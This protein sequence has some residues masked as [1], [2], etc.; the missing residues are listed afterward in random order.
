MDNGAG[1]V[2]CGVVFFGPYDR[3]LELKARF[4]NEIT[5]SGCVFVFAKTVPKP[6]RLLLVEEAAG[7]NGNG[8]IR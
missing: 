7:Q 4:E 2:S 1:R 3:A 8:V 5:S 6:R